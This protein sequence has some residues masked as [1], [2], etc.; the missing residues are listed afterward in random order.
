MEGSEK[1]QRCASRNAS[2][3][4]Y[5]QG[6]E[7]AVMVLKEEWCGRGIGV[8]PQTLLNFGVQAS[9]FRIFLRFV[10]PRH[11]PDAVEKKRISYTARRA[12][13]L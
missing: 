9:T 5:N 6:G 7:N 4:V 10:Y 3:T 2:V 13:S 8:S 12:Q 1:F 11:A